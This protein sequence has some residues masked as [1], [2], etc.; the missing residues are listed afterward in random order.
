M[1]FTKINM[2]IDDLWRLR[3]KYLE[4]LQELKNKH[5]QIFQFRSKLLKFLEKQFCHKWVQSLLDRAELLRVK[6]LP[7]NAKSE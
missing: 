4:Q 1:Q 5:R 3:K 7:N 6:E 2:I